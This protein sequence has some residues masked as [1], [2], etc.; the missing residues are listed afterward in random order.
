M[1]SDGSAALGELRLKG[2]LAFAQSD[3]EVGSMPASAVATGNVDYFCSAADIGALVSGLSP[4]WH[5]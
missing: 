2:G 4:M 3:A 1:A 5:S